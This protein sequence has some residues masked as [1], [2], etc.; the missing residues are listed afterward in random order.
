MKRKSV[1]QY[2]V[3]EEFRQRLDDDVELAEAFRALTPGR[4]KGYLL[5]FGAAK[6]SATRT[7]RME[8]SAPRILKGLGLNDEPRWLVTNGP[9]V[10][11]ANPFDL[12]HDSRRTSISTVNN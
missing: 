12:G 6:Q 7:A 4:Q 9:E 5:Y 3:P 11:R 1:A 8:K 2:D 10:L